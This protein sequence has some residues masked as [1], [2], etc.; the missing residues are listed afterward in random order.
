[1]LRSLYKGAA[2]VVKKQA[3]TI[4][5]ANN[6]IILRDAIRN[7]MEQHAPHIKIAADGGTFDE[8]LST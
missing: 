8:V 6:H 4:M 3:I 5:Y 2:A 1:M 7:M